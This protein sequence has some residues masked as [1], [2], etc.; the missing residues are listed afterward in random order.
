MFFF[1]RQPTLLF[2]E[3]PWSYN[4]YYITEHINGRGYWQC[5]GVESNSVQFSSSC[6]ADVVEQSKFV[7]KSFYW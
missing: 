4:R 7:T 6:R 3:C 5:S 1:Y 2:T